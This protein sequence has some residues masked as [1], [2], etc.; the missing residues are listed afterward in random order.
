MGNIFDFG[1][2]MK[3]SVSQTTSFNTSYWGKVKKGSFGTAAAAGTLAIYGLLAPEPAISKG[4]A[5]GCL[6]VAGLAL[7]TG[8]CSWGMESLNKEIGKSIDKE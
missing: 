8:L 5:I 4:V 1:D 6:S 3:N 2:Q 7:V